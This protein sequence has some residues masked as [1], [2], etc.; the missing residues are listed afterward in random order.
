MLIG[1]LPLKEI[2]R[3][4]AEWRR[5][6]AKRYFEATGRWVRAADRHIFDLRYIHRFSVG[7]AA[8]LDYEE[9]EGSGE[10]YVVLD[11]GRVGEIHDCK[12]PLGDYNGRVG[13]TIF[14]SAYTWTAAVGPDYF[15]PV[16]FARAGWVSPPFQLEPS[17]ENEAL[18]SDD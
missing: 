11:D 18:S 16:Y 1:H 10:V 7:P 6:F 15:D 4:Q 8:Q 12:P 9:A 13:A 5:V 2:W 17:T 14:P 3:V